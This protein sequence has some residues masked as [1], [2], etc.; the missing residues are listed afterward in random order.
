[1]KKKFDKNYVK[2]AFSPGVETLGIVPLVTMPFEGR[3]VVFSQ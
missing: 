3:F 2:S 1:M